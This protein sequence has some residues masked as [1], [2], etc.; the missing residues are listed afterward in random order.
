LLLII[1]IVA[2]VLWLGSPLDW[3]LVGIAA[4][5]EIG[6]TAFWF[7]WTG[8]RR[9]KVG[10]E[11]LVG[12]RA[13]VVVPC[14]PDGQVRVDGELWQARCEEGAGTGE[15]VVVE[16]IEGLTLDVRTSRSAD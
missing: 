6:E 12:R 2:A 9:A 1:A 8:R 10:V 11:T 14:L 7:W 5:L 3:I 13:T 15:T 4:V 16:R